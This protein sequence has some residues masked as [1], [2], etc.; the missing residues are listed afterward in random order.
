MRKDEKDE[1]SRE[2]DAQYSCLLRMNS[3]CRIEKESSHPRLNSSARKYITT[4]KPEIQ[5][6]SKCAQL[7]PGKGYLI[8]NEPEYVIYCDAIWGKKQGRKCGRSPIYS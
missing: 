8:G 7:S 6:H 5:E 3:Q 4:I 2:S 1:T